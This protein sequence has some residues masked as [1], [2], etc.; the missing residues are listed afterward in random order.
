MNKISICTVCMNRLKH[1]AKT[2]PVNIRENMHYPGIEFVLL[3]YNSKDGLSNW[4]RSNLSQYISSG[5]LKY[6]KTTEPQYFDLSHSKNMALKLASG[7]IIGL[8][9]ADNYAGPAYVDWVNE[10]F[11]QHGEKTITTTLMKDSI[12]FRDQGGKL[13]FSND[14]FRSVNGF[15]E[16]MIVY[17]IED[18]DLVN[19]LEKAGGKRV[20]IDQDKYRQYIG[21][22]NVERLVNH[23]LP[24]DVDA[25]LMRVS[26][27]GTDNSG[28]ILYLLRDHSFF[29]VSYA[30]DSSA[31]EDWVNS[32]AGWSIPPNGQK[33]GTFDQEN[34]GILLKFKEGQTLRLQEKDSKAM[35]YRAANDNSSWQCI[36]KDDAMYYVVLMA[37]G[38]CVNR[39][40]F[41]ENDKNDKSVNQDG[42]G[43]GTVYLN[44]DMTNPIG[45]V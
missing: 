29:E 31:H 44:F 11:N 38:E 9:D 12:P 33:E 26:E 34:K 24:N 37:Y 39:N 16:S 14:A 10:S 3:D 2:L 15:D 42:W 28:R 22:S 35:S 32:F 30:F 40:K 8:V 20:F 45:I 7:N 25:I 18:V 1:L 27:E 13:C 36:P 6:Y 41:M 19:R 43:K 21:H 23:R 5:I 4:V 17:G